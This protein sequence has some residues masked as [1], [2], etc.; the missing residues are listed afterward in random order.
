MQIW[1]GVA[2]PPPHLHIIGSK[3]FLSDPIELRFSGE[4]RMDAVRRFPVF[5]DDLTILGYPT[6]EISSHT[7]FKTG[8]N[9]L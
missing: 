1:G 2:S 9:L 5:F 8:S 6:L 4:F 3:K 7:G